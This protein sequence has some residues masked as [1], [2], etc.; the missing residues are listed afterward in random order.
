MTSLT[1][2]VELLDNSS[3]HN[4]VIWFNRHP[5]IVPVVADVYSAKEMY[6]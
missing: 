3:D 4:K 5:M 2:I 1:T 6:R